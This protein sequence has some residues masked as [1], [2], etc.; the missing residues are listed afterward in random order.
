MAKIKLYNIPIEDV[1][2]YHNIVGCYSQNDDTSKMKTQI[3]KFKDL[4]PITKKTKLPDNTYQIDFQFRRFLEKVYTEFDGGITDKTEGYNYRKAYLG[5][6]SACLNLN[7]LEETST[8]FELHFRRLNTI[9]NIV[10]SSLNNM[11]IEDVISLYS[12][13]KK[14][15]REEIEKFQNIKCKLTLL[16]LLSMTNED[17]K[18]YVIFENDNEI[19]IDKLYCLVRDNSSKE[20]KQHN[21]TYIF[22]PSYKEVKKEV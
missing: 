22:R 8:D 20:L 11:E 17:I 4:S 18:D 13:I 21:K 19:D 2:L 12:A 1:I 6:L 3:S 15:D 16:I 7:L 9:L 5:I 14:E 10:L